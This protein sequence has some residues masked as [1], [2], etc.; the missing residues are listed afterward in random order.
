MVQAGCDTNRLHPRTPNR[1]RPSIRCILFDL[2]G[3]LY[4]SSQYSRR[5]EAE[6]L[7]IV[8]RELNLDEKHAKKLLDTRRKRIGTLTRTIESLGI[9]RVE[10]YRALARRISPHL[11]LSR[12]VRE[13]ELMKDL[14]KRGFRLGL[15]SNS[16]RPLANKILKAIHLEPRL[17]DVIVTSTEAEPKPSPGPFLLAMK[18]LGCEASHTIYVGDRDE[19]ELR[20]AKELG[21]RTVL[22]DRT[23]NGP[24]RWADYIVHDVSEMTELASG[25]L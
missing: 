17:F 5:L 3:T 24:S 6:I 22:V 21:L 20:P 23:G 18:H 25:I 8:G 15:V 14:R 9:D 19:A 2:D 7:G 1:E 11:Y 4:Q 12:A 16:G 10:F 13:R